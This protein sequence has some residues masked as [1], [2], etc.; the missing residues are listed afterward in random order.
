M[1]HA[2]MLTWTV[3]ATTTLTNANQLQ[4]ITGSDGTAGKR[5]TPNEACASK[6]PTRKEEPAKKRPKKQGIDILKE[7]YG[8]RYER[9]NFAHDFP[10]NIKRTRR[11]TADAWLLQFER[12]VAKREAEWPSVDVMRS[13]LAEIPDKVLEKAREQWA[14]RLTEVPSPPSHGSRCWHL[15]CEPLSAP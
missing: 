10:L 3:H 5:K 14:T 4:A 8:D 1:L 11:A 15:Q 12:R 2:N 7:A 9:L 13:T 6:Q